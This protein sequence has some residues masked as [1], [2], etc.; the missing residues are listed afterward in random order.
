M[1]ATQQFRLPDVGE[2]LT[3]AEV[4][5]WRVQPGDSVDVN[6]IVVEIET[7][8]SIVEL[9]VPFAGTVAELLVGVG[10]TVA[11]GTPLISVS[12]AGGEV[13]PELSGAAA[14]DRTAVLVGYGPR[15]AGT[16]RRP[17]KAA[18]V[19]SGTSPAVAQQAVQSAFSTDDQPSLATPAV[20][21]AEPAVPNGLEQASLPDRPGGRRVLAKPP[22][23]KL[24]KD[25][26]VDLRAVRP[27]GAD[28]IVTRADVEAHARSL[29]TPPVQ[30]AP[31]G[32][33]VQPVQ[34]DSP[35]AAGA[36]TRVAVRGVRKATAQAMVASAFTAPHVT[37]WVELDATRTVRLVR[38]LKATREF[39]DVKL[40]P[41]LVVAKA[42]CLA[43]RRTPELNASWDEAAQEIV[44]RQDVN[45]G[46]AVAS[47][48]GLLVPNVKAA[49]QLTLRQL[50]DALSALTATAREGRTQPSDM[51]GGSFTLTNVG[52]FGIDSGTPIL[53]PGES[54][55][56]AMG[57]IRR[58]PWVVAGEVR[59]R[60]V[61]TLAVSFDHRVADG[62]Q[63]SR[64]LADVAAIVHEPAQALLY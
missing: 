38:S 3:E 27:S 52:V 6:D 45:L 22:V 13:E 46:I 14:G 17:R 23:R 36:E 20:E 63:G 31:P 42:V 2:G 12:T 62:E 26:G 28:H 25:L 24:A 35:A 37:E 54:G 7:A 29:G 40:S 47:P 44:L 9:P 57:A 53:N 51:T 5:G 39:A 60:C 34:P 33:P 49:Q 15:T 1:S 41:M 55:I 61:T 32:L 48:R 16:R 10:E 43:A 50:A 19:P 58:K 56:L 64:F 8:K 30:H 11:V 18:I 59:P 4:V 21:N